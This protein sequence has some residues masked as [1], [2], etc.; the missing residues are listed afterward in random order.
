VTAVFVH[1]VPYLRGMCA[2]PGSPA[3]RSGPVSEMVEEADRSHG[4]VGA[5]GRLARS[6]DSRCCGAIFVV[7]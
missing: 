2:R 6:A 5:T 4:R 3:A 1:E 7:A